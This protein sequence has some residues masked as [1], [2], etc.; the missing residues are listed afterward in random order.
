MSNNNNIPATIE[1]QSM[2]DSHSS[3]FVVV[4]RDYR[5]LAVNQAYEQFYNA[6]RDF[7]VGQPCYQVSHGNSAP[8]HESGED[9]PHERLFNKGEQHS[10]LHVHYDP[11]HR[12]HQVRVTAYPLV[13]GDGEL[14]MGEMIEEINV[15]DGVH[16]E[17]QRM[18]GKSQ[19]F[20]AC[21]Q[22][23]NLVAAG[24]IP[25]LL[26]GE[27]GTGKELAASYVHANSGRSDQPY[28]TVDCTVLT[29]T[30]FEAEVFGHARGA[31]TGSIGERTGLFAQ[32][33]GGTLFLDE[34]GELPP[35]QQA[36]LLRVLETGQYRRV[37][38]RGTRKADVRLI[39]ATNCHLWEL[40]KEGKFREDLYYR[41]AC[42][43][44][45]MPSLRE[46]SEDIPLLANGLLVPISHSMNRRLHVTPKA[47]ERLQAYDYPGN[48]R[49]LRNI[50]FV[51]ATH[52]KNG[53]INK[54][55]IDQAM[56]QLKRTL[57]QQPQ[58]ATEGV[59]HG[60]AG[61]DRGVPAQNATNTSVEASLKELEARHIAD[62]LALNDGN[63]RQVAGELGISER[64]L[65]RK[66]KK[67][68]LNKPA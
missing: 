32:A 48:I 10:C 23:L 8:C 40:V 55:L 1:L 47:V 25:V 36:K 30:L 63:R 21:V 34:V 43:T 9:C 7:A 44:V 18:I 52:S 2:I 35:T 37:G 59:A 42:L 28:I 14:Y 16:R 66:L 33:D 45:R 27:T 6:T 17:G 67:Y 19:P 39:C 53:H 31:F 15:P 50:L 20:T 64:T 68:Q 5:I 56:G 54:A 58:A 62:L 60:E 57:E 4:G 65:Y 24:D 38:G 12:M 11:D 49:E 61:Q 41:I 51:A 46:R 26:Q 22:Q 3:P 29:D 13:S